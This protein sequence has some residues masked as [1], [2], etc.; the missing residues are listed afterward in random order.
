MLCSLLKTITVLTSFYHVH[1]YGKET[2][3]ATMARA[4]H[5]VTIVNNKDFLPCFTH[6]RVTTPI[7]PLYQFRI[8]KDHQY[9]IFDEQADLHK[10]SRN[11]F[12][13]KPEMYITKF[14]L[15]QNCSYLTL[16]KQVQ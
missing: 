8:G 2:V 13:E 16:L 11:Y 12:L 10:T 1:M 6:T 9:V 7:Q 5:Q 15:N 14:W 4:N 3:A